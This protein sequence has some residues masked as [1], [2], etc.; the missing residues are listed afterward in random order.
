M[1]I[2]DANP[3][4]IPISW[5]CGR[6]VGCCIRL[7]R[8]ILAVQA[9]F[10]EHD[11]RVADWPIGRRNRAL[12]E[13]RCAV[14]GAALRGWIACRQCSEQLEFEIDG[15]SLAAVRRQNA[16]WCR[17]MLFDCQPAGTWRRLCMNRMRPSPPGDCFS[18]AQRTNCRRAHGTRSRLEIVGESMAA[19]DPA[20]G[21]Q[22]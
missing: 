2:K 8:G 13:L 6:P 10:P 3:P 5:R 16:C 20:G 1:W 7:T 21:D 14:F 9:A 11:G 15:R 12:A 22:A 18:S 17:V 19:T 4:P